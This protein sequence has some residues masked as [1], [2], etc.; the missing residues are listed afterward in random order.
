MTTPLAERELLPLEQA[1][2]DVQTTLDELL[3]SADEQHAAIAAGDRA[4]LESITR[5]QESLS[6]R[7]E[8]AERQRMALLDGRAL[9]E[10]LATL[11]AEDAARLERMMSSI[12]QTVVTLRE[13]QASTASLLERSI[14]LAGQTIQFLQRLVVSQTQ[15]YTVR[16]LPA[17]SHSLLLDSR[18]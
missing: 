13:R 17:P 12:G 7:L 15:A 18:A 14:D 1:L 10:A 16:G 5:R 2:L 6:A 9:P 8:R 3:T 4:R 11:P